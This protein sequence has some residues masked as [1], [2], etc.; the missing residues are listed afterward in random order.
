MMSHRSRM[1]IVVLLG[2]TVL[3]LNPSILRADPPPSCVGEDACTAGSG[4]VGAGA[5]IGELSCFG[6]QGDVGAGACIGEASCFGHEGD[7]AK[8][9]CHD[10]RACAFN[11]GSVGEG[12]CHGIAACFRIPPDG[13][14]GPPPPP[15]LDVQKAGCIGVF[16]CIGNTGTVERLPVSATVPAKTAGVTSAS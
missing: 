11:L 3:L 2:F 4:A 9:G 6:H 8:N 1:V 13:D 5:C 7:V 12:A 16:A 10:F 15:R 14:D